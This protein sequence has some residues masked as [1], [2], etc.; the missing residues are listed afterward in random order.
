MKSFFQTLFASFLALTLFAILLVVLGLGIAAGLVK[1]ASK[2]EPKIENGSFLVVDL[3]VN[4]TDTPVSFE[5]SKALAHLLGRDDADTV[6][7]RALLGAIHNAADD[8]RIGGIFLSG[9]FTPQD[10]GAGFAA[11]KEVREA[12]LDFRKSKK[13]VIAYLVGPNTRDYYLASVAET[14]Y[15]NPFGEMD[16]PGM[17]T[18]PT[19]F[20][21]ALDK[22]GVGVQVVRHGKY[23]RVGVPAAADRCMRPESLLIARAHRSRQATT[24]GRVRSPQRSIALGSARIS[25]S[26]PRR[27]RAP[28]PPKTTAF[29]P[30]RTPLAR[31]WN[32]AAKRS[33]GHIF[34]AQLAVGQSATTGT[35]A[36]SSVSALARSA[37]P[38]QATGTGAGSN[39]SSAACCWYIRRPGM[40]RRIWRCRAK[41]A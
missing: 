8:K 25:G 9:S 5:S 13:P 2:Q 34:G 15:L 11:L 33:A 37:G 41:T 19:F 39:P 35:P 21:G 36:G 18:T 24:S 3:S 23:P 12:L 16:L 6:S 38:V 28:G 40:G 22:Y 31:R 4:L 14:I 20:K 10:Y 30:G 27:S 32:S 1:L 29:A 26:A 17:A 7:L